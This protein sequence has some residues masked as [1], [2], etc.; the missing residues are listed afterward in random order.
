MDF[1]VKL[2]ESMEPG[3]RTLCDAI[4]VRVDRLTKF[5]HFEA[6]TESITAVELSYMVISTIV[7]NHSMPDE[8]VSDRDKLFTSKFWSSLMNRLGTKQ[9]MSMA[10]YP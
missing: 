4:W 9:K 6:T 7:A 3:S 5:A 8:I 10:F 1:I 2:L